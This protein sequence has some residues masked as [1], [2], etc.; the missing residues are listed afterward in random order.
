MGAC[1]SIGTS[2]NLLISTLIVGVYDEMTKSEA[3]DPNVR[4]FPYIPAA[5]MG[6]KTSG[7]VGHHQMRDW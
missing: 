4:S 6:R 2:L 5:C 3:Q 7:P 1:I